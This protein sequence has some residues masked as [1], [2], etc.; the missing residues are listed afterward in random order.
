M[1]TAALRSRSWLAPQTGHVHART[2]SGSSSRTCP[3]HEHIFEDG[4]Q[5]LTFT[6]RRP[7]QA[8]LYSSWRAI[9]DM[10][11]SATDLARR[12]FFSI[13]LTSRSSTA[14][15]WLSRTASVVALWM[16]SFLWFAIRSWMRATFLFC[17]RLLAEPFRLRDRRL[18]SRAS[19]LSPLAS[20]LG[21]AILMPSERVA[22]S[23]TPASTPITGVLASGH[24]STG[25]SSTP[26]TQKYL[27]EGTRLMVA[28]TILPLTG[29]EIRALTRPSLGSFMWRA[30][31]TEMPQLVL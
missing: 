31:G 19:F 10:E 4:Y 12:R 29:R 2:E 13:P 21:F 23:F 30:S 15:A 7:C 25:A 27:P 22:R 1:L 28:D 16:A 17:F 11:A 26:S 18:C 20:A 24:S 6:K 8:H 3:Q 5:R 9:S 14:M